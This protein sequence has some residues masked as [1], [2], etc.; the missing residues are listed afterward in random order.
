M[1]KLTVKRALKEYSPADNANVL[2]VD[3]VIEDEDGVKESSQAFP[4]GTSKDD[5]KAELKKA[6]ETHGIEKQQAKENAE[7]EAA[8]AQT[9]EAIQELQDLTIE[10]GEKV[11]EV[12]ESQPEEVKPQE[13]ASEGATEQTQ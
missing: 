6:L 4:L 7:K 5:M 13:N 12:A 1:A 3:F 2:R 10:E 9:D 11:E 8:E